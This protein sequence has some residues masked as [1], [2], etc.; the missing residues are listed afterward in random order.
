M[1]CDGVVHTLAVL[2][3]RGWIP[4]GESAAE[5]RRAYAPPAGEIVVEGIARRSQESTFGPQDPAPRLGESRL[6]AWFQ[7][8]IPRIAGQAGYPLL[9][10]YVEQQPAPGD[11]P[12]PRRVAAADLGEGPH[13]SYAVQWFAF[14]LILLV[15]Y[16][17]FT[18]QQLRRSNDRALGSIRELR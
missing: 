17:A 3:D 11:P 2:V 14:A 13:L 12:L 1:H 9:P 7:V 4:M 10:I 6:D 16:V 18:R 5:Q 15:S 8:N